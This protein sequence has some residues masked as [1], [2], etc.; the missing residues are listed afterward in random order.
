MLNF[1]LCLFLHTPKHLAILFQHTSDTLTVNTHIKTSL[2]FINYIHIH[3]LIR[4]LYAL[5]QVIS[6]LMSKMVHGQ[7]RAIDRTMNLSII[8]S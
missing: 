4:K 5:L 7:A 2:L 8:F 1:F 6:I 3:D